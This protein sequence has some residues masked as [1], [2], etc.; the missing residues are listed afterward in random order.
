MLQKISNVYK[1]KRFFGFLS[2]AIRIFLHK[3]FRIR[4][5]GSLSIASV[6]TE[7]KIFSNRSLKYSDDGYFFVDPMP[8]I[9][10]LNEYYSSFYWEPNK[11]AK[12]I[13]GANSRDFLHY[14]LLKEYIPQEL[15]QGKV[16][17]N[18]GAGHG[19]ISHL[20]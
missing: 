2:L 12:K 19:G 7:Q 16:F 14:N 15:S 11:K 18:F 13:H 5:V 20:C 1:E 17:L 6:S 8:S 9:D 3:V 4:L 10:E